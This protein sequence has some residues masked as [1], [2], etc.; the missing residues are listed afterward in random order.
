M[1]PRASKQK[2]KAAAR[3]GDPTTAVAVPP[4][5]APWPINAEVL[6]AL[7]NLWDQINEFTV[8]N[9]SGPFLAISSHLWFIKNHLPALVS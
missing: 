6:E 1:A 3:Q 5:Q 2:G 8:L 9:S 7:Q 4:V